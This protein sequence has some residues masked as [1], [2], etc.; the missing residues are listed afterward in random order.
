[1]GN[2][3]LAEN[4]IQ[5][6]FY[7]SAA[8]HF[9][10]LW[11]REIQSV[12]KTL[13]VVIDTQPLHEDILLTLLIK[14]EGI[15]NIKPLG[16]VSSDL[17]DPDPVIP[18]MLLMGLW[19]ASLPQVTYVPDDLTKRIW[20]HCQMMADH[21][22]AKFLRHHLLALQVKQKWQRLTANLEQGTVAMIVDP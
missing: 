13:Q 14:V 22:W 19:G 21:F 8:P 3:R 9:G 18:N 17:A 1:M 10:G 20:S 12:K 6:K 4:Q 2:W 11:E 15:L 5:C 7:P 16:F